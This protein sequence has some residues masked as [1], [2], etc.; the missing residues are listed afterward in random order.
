MPTLPR[1]TRKK[2]Q[3]AYRLCATARSVEGVVGIYNRI[4]PACLE[5]WTDGEPP[6][7]MAGVEV[8][9]IACGDCAPSY[10]VII[11]VGD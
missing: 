8:G 6:E 5:R 7:C 4:C 11:A 10:R 2:G 9:I 1:S 3:A